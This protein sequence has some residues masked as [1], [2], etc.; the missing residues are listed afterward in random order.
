MA[1]SLVLLRLKTAQLMNTYRNSVSAAVSDGIV[2]LIGLWALLGFAFIFWELGSSASQAAESFPYVVGVGAG[3]VLVWLASPFFVTSVL[4]DVRQFATY[5]I[6]RRGLLAGLTL[7]SLATPGGVI[8][9][10]YVPLHLLLF[11]EDPT[12]VAAVAVGAPLVLTYL[13]MLHQVSAVAMA[14]WLGSRGV[15]TALGLALLSL[16]VVA[17]PTFLLGQRLLGDVEHLLQTVISWLSF[18][19]LGAPAALPYDLVAGDWYS[20][21]ARLLVVLVTVAVALGVLRMGLGRVME[22]P[23]GHRASAKLLSRGEVGFFALF[24]AS[25]TAA[26]AARSLTYWFR[27]PRYAFKLLI[28]PG[29]IFALVAVHLVTGAVWP[30]YA[31][32]PY[33]AFLV[34][35]VLIGDVSMDYTAFALHVTSGISGAADRWGRTLAALILGLPAVLAA[36]ALPVLAAEGLR[37][38]LASGG[39]SVGLFLSVLGMS[40]WFSVRT[41]FPMV[42]PGDSPMKAPPGAGGRAAAIQGIGLLTVL[43]LSGLEIS[44]LIGWAVTGLPQ[45]VAVATGWSLV[46]GMGVLALGHWLGARQYEKRLPELYQQ[47]AAF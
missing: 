6:G 30:L 4:M 37:P 46:K 19:P 22:N 45:L 29:I 1:A 44:L 9:C 20:F 41:V 32:G 38:A 43:V 17:Y 5:P 36:G 39:L 31:V 12:A 25:P 7:S 47:I 35:F 42:K 14:A 13:T 3:L 28:L 23:A 2:L 10:I 27:D 21:A 18:S 34:G 24:P 15:R 40:A 8:T 16:A 26:V 33:T 11:R